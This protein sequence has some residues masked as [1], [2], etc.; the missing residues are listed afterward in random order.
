M[1]HT[2]NRPWTVLSFAS[3]AVIFLFAHTALADSTVE[4]EVELKLPRSFQ[5]R[6]IDKQWNSLQERQFATTLP[7]PDQSL[8]VTDADVQLA[9]LQLD[10]QT[11]LKKPAVPLPGPT[12]VLESTNLAAHLKI[13]SVSV[14][15][16][17]VREIGGVIVRVHLQAAC[18]NLDL[19]MAPG[20]GTFKMQLSPTVNGSRIA[21]H[22]EDMD[23]AWTPH[24]WSLGPMTCTGA[25]G[26]E[27]IVTTQ[28]L[29]LVSNSAVL[30]ERKAELM[31]Y[32]QSY[33]E[34]QSVDI[35][36]PRILTSH[37]PDIQYSLRV[38][39]LQSQGQTLIARGV[40]SAR[41][42]NAPNEAPIY[43]P[44]GATSKR[45]D[46]GAAKIRVPEKFLRLLLTR[47]FTAGSWHAQ[48]GS[49]NIPGFEQFR[50]NRILACFLWP[51]LES[52]PWNTPFIFD[53]TSSKPLGIQGFD[54]NY[55]IASE[56]AVRMSAVGAN[57][58]LTPFMQFRIPLESR[59][60]VSVANGVLA[61]KFTGVSLDIW[62]SFV[63]SF[64]QAHHP[65]E[66]FAADLL[67]NRLIAAGEGTQLNYPLPVIQFLDLPSFRV[68]NVSTSEPGAD[69]VF[70]LK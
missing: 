17:I 27:D 64:V 45:T 29:N 10:I 44:L 40:L 13:Q 38:S 52:F 55:T 56:L 5:Q 65:S 53:V 34:T 46:D 22:L 26:F 30:T 61:G 33:L 63:P 1:L 69:L 32:V 50:S 18:Q 48:V 70:S 42:K 23:V 58:S 9:G 68:Q 25:Q 8:H 21:A 54:L 12:V 35:S 4:S 28:I 15:Q 37:R 39:N 19:T 3:S 31:T 6:I 62:P 14:D 20:E 47:A 2:R 7:L 51:A 24:A 66:T 60:Q 36:K 57:K 41:F 43:L 11:S 67:E 59:V 16:F 49:A